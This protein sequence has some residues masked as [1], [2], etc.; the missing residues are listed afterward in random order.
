MNKNRS[1][2]FSFSFFVPRQ[3]PV[4]FYVL[5]LPHLR[6]ALFSRLFRKFPFPLHVNLDYVLS[7]IYTYRLEER[8][9]FSVSWVIRRRFD[10][11]PRRIFILNLVTRNLLQLKKKKKKKQTNAGQFCVSEKTHLYLQFC[12]FL[13]FSL[14]AE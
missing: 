3:L 12:G 1:S 7:C 4:T 2:P 10:R 5:S 11:H 6:A 9:R 8:R 13:T 14:T